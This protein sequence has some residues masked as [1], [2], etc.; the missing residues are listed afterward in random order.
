MSGSAETLVIRESC[1]RVFSPLRPGAL[2]GTY[3]I[4]D[5]L[6]QGAI[7]IVYL[8]QHTKLKRKV[9]IKVLRDELASNEKAVV[10][11]FGEARAVNEIAHENIV[12]IT[13]FVEAEPSRGI[14]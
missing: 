3:E 1:E 6:G 8:A 5:L 9:A 2:L 11:F 14:P 10:R 13:D 12:E 4:L 7:G